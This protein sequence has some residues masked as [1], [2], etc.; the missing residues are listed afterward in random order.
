MVDDWHP[1]PLT[2]ED[3]Q[4]QYE[5]PTIV[6]TP[7]LHPKVLVSGK[8]DPISAVNLASSNFSGLAGNEHIKDKAIECL[9]SYGVGSCGPPGF[10]GTFDVHI[11][12]EKSLAQFLGVE[13]AIIYTQGF[14]TVSSVIPAFAKRGDIIV[15]DRGVN[16][17]IQKGIQISRCTVYWYDHNDMDDLER[18]LRKVQS[19]NRRKP[20]TR[21]FIVS[22][23]LFEM[24]GQVVDL[25]RLLELKVA[26][27][28]RLVLDETWSFGIL[29]EAGRGITEAFDVPGT[30]VDIIVGSMAVGLCASGGFCAGSLEICSHQVRP[31]TC[32]V[33]NV[34]SHNY[35]ISLLTADQLSCLRLLCSFTTPARRLGDRSAALFGHAH[36]S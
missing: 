33:R 28:Y 11:N 35:S 1:E 6:G 10:Y 17:A 15:A 22:E 32:T 31:Q 18:V 34:G 25:P 12:L 30:D 5:P 8:T 16:F 7:T 21:R 36:E 27:K 23:A 4:D 13:A 14:S 19:D 2:V 9:R 20:L 29:G 3:P 26:F 24:D